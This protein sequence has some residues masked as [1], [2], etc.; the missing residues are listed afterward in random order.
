MSTHESTTRSHWWPRVFGVVLGL[1]GLALLIGG[2]R[3]ATLGGSWYYLI[4]GAATLVSGV[5]LVRGKAE[6]SLLFFAVVVGTAIWSLTEVGTQFWGLVP[7]L[8]PM[9]VLGV[10]AALALRSLRPDAKKLAVPAA[11]VQAAV[12]AV[13]A[14]GVFTPH[15]EVYNAKVDKIINDIPVVTDPASPANNFTQFGRDE[16]GTRFGPYDQINASNVNKLEVAWTYRT[17]AT[18]GFPNEDVGAPIHVNGTMYLC[19]P[20]NKVIAVD[21]TSGQEKWVF[22]PQSKQTKHWQRCRGV[23]YFE[24]P[25]A[26]K[27]ADGHCNTRIITTDK[28]TRLWAVDAKDGKLCEGFGDTGKGYSDLSVGMGEYK[29]WYYMQTSQPLVA[30][31]RAIVGGWVWDGKELDEPSGVIRAYNLMDGSLDWA[32]DLGNP[33]ITKL[34]PEGETYTKGTPNWWTHGAYD[35]KLGLIYLP[36]GNPT[37]DF[38]LNHRTK[39][40]N[41]YSTSVVALNVK[42]GREVW[43]FHTVHLDVWDYDNATPPTLVDLPDG[44]PAL[45]MGTKTHQ[46]FTLDRRTGKPVTEVTEVPAPADDETLAAGELPSAPTQPWSTGMPQLSK[47]TLTE[48]DMWGTTMFDQLYCRI[49]FKQLHFKGAYTRIGTKPTLAYPGYYGG[50]NWGGHAYDPRTN[51][52]IVNDMNIPQIVFLAPQE[53]AAQTVKDMNAADITK[54]GWKNSH[55]QTG[56]PYQAIRGVLNS[57]LGVPCNMPSWGNI[58]G[59]DMNTKKIAWMKPIGTV[60]DTAFLGMKTGLPV[61]LGMPTLSG[62][63]VTAGGLTFYAGT[64][65]YYVRAFETATGKEVWKHRLPVGSQV[66]PTTYLGADGRQYLVVVAGGA[67]QSPDRSDHV[68]AFALPK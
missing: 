40:M 55:V 46:I 12:I 27:R 63:S 59:I 37:P 13:G 48:E 23:G 62:P 17:G 15:S 25:E 4:A 1:E 64:Q 3:L 61:P 16:A 65:D 52:L 58:A 20:Q 26:Q 9:L 18:L 51:M 42:T 34:P 36:L 29:E 39:A 67:R 57:F 44:T 24:V 31:G 38:S 45:I 53:T 50:F 41:D 49:K 7:R 19:T 8:A 10:I 5:L 43:K 68:M 22:D 32:W 66:A 14:V 28:Q 21:A 60:E 35:A 56:T 33:E 30:D 2:I 11:A 47:M 6:G 54:A